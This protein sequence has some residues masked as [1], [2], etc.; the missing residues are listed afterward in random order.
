M[1]QY[2][3]QKQYRLIIHDN[4]NDNELYTYGN[5]FCIMYKALYKSITYELSFRYIIEAVD[6]WLVVQEKSTFQ[7]LLCIL[8]ALVD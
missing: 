3:K 6:D 1:N 7:S 2:R 4:A 8:Y 5:R